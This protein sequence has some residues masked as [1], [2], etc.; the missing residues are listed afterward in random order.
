MIDCG[1]DECEHKEPGTDAMLYMGPDA[2]WLLIVANIRDGRYE[3]I[4]AW[5]DQ[6]Q[7]ANQAAFDATERRVR[8]ALAMAWYR[9]QQ[10]Q[11]ARA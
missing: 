2:T 10:F 7:H 8:K 3:D 9:V 1:C 5:I 11:A 6:R 4:Q